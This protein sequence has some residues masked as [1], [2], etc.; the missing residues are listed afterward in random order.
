MIPMSHCS[1]CLFRFQ[2]HKNRL[3][4]VGV[5][6]LFVASK[7]EEVYPPKANEF[8]L[9]TDGTFSI[10]EIYKME[11]LVLRKMDWDVISV[12]PCWWISSMV[13]R[14]HAAHQT[15]TYSKNSLATEGR[16]EK[17]CLAMGLVDMALLGYQSMRF[18]PS[19]LAAAAI[20]LSLQLDQFLLEQVTGLEM[21]TIMP[22]VKWMEEYLAI[23]RKDRGHWCT[24]ENLYRNLT[25]DRDIHM[26]QSHDPDALRN[27]KEKLW[28]APTPLPLQAGSY[29]A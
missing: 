4:L 28:A 12:T 10:T 3:Q 8:A 13:H 19:A 6:A 11:R 27:L 14:V 29:G 1:P 9:I 20:Y 23:T 2:V 15:A 25:C 24:K 7:V 17:F 21:S 18:M 22:C 16:N 26:I 5:A